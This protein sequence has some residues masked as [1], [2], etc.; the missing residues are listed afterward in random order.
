M[1][2]KAV[3]LLFAASLSKLY[4]EK[5][6]SKKADEKQQRAKEMLAK[7]K[8]KKKQQTNIK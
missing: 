5:V 4:Q 2:S 1:F 7:N 8:T 6:K 3:F